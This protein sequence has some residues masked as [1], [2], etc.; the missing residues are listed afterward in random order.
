MF[1]SF[2]TEHM[3]NFLT[4]FGRW[5]RGVN[6]MLLHTVNLDHSCVNFNFILPCLI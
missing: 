6:F 2:V 5:Y 1:Q 4:L 3:R